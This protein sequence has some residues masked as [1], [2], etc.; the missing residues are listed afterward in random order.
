MKKLYEV[1]ILDPTTASIEADTDPYKLLLHPHKL[2][3]HQHKQ[4]LHPHKLLVHQH[5]WVVGWYPITRHQ[6]SGCCS[7][8]VPVARLEAFRALKLSKLVKLC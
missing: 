6:Q 3:L 7:D 8:V 2:L 1:T 5:V 4:L